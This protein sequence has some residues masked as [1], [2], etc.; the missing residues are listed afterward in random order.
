MAEAG[1]SL[2]GLDAIVFGRGPGSLL[3]CVSVLVRH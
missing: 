3:V 1:A 2:Q